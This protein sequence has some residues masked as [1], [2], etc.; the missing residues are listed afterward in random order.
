MGE[1]LRLTRID[2]RSKKRVPVKCIVEY[3]FSQNLAKNIT[4]MLKKIEF[5][6]KTE[7]AMCLERTLQNKP[8]DMPKRDLL[9][10]L[11]SFKEESLNAVV[12]ERELYYLVP[13]SFLETRESQA[14]S[15]IESV[16]KVSKPKRSRSKKKGELPKIGDKILN[17]HKKKESE[18]E[19]KSAESND[20]P[21][22]AEKTG[23]DAKGSDLSSSEGESA[24]KD[25]EASKRS[26]GRLP[27]SCK[28]KATK[29][30]S[31][32]EKASKEKAT[33]KEEKKSGRTSSKAGGLVANA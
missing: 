22:D 20:E 11:Q 2:A 16:K 19:E 28:G 32:R 12:I 9:V 33:A 5:K 3:D 8:W 15:T 21:R 6:G 4:A 31:A 17:W 30:Y 26:L 24:S 10:N 7:Y 14:S 25:E 29:D 27:R 1:N 18:P 13:T 23:G